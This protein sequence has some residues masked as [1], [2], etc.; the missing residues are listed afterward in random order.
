MR[1]RSKAR[2]PMPY[3]ATREDLILAVQKIAKG[4]SDKKNA[5]LMSAFKL[6]FFEAGSGGSGQVVKD[7]VE[8]DFLCNGKKKLGLKKDEKLGS[9]SVASIIQKEL[10]VSK[11]TAA[12]I[13]EAHSQAPAALIP[14]CLAHAMLDKGEITIS[15]PQ[16]RKINLVK[17]NDQIYVDID[18]DQFPVKLVAENKTIGEIGKCQCRF[19]LKKNKDKWGFEL[20]TVS[21]D[22]PFVMAALK[23]ELFSTEQVQA[24][25]AGDP[26]AINH[27]S[28][29]AKRDPRDVTYYG[30]MAGIAPDE[31]TAKDI[32]DKHFQTV[33]QAS[34]AAII[35]KSSGEGTTKPFENQVRYVMQDIHTKNKTLADPVIHTAAIET[36]NSKNQ[37]Y[38]AKFYFDDISKFKGVKRDCT[39]L[40]KIPR[41]SIPGG[42][43]RKWAEARINSYLAATDEAT[44]SRGIEIERGEM[45]KECDEAMILCCMDKNLKYTTQT[46]IKVSGAQLRL[47]QSKQAEEQL[48]QLQPSSSLK[49]R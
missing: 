35:A 7:F 46:S 34:G 38:H 30:D 2:K 42:P 48:P 39:T 12:H 32:I 27:I 24:Y 19:A 13:V 43:Y 1:P 44:Q 41:C 36:V 47:Y 3:Q 4:M 49:I 10:K 18:F 45:P 8:R 5:Y 17:D 26:K 31:K 14:F 22:D 20:E 15:Q 25:L 21:S 33:M 37:S 9:R 23:G 29:V 28:K 16:I 6:D 40:F 11:K